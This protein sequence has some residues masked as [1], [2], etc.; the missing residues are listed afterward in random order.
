MRD[1]AGRTAFVTGAASGIGFALARAF[2]AEG[3][4]VMLAD[5]E[6]PALDAAVGRLAGG[7][8]LDGLAPR[9][10]HLQDRRRGIGAA[11]A[12]RQHQQRRG[13]RSGADPNHSHTVAHCLL[14]AWRC[15]SRILS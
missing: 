12:A 13:D 15:A 5:I 10:Q 14:S 9:F 2:A 7:A 1:L 11:V 6:A 8:A 3:M 4:N